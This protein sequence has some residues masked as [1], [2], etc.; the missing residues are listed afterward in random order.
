MAAAIAITAAA[1]STTAATAA[2]TY[3]VVWYDCYCYIGTIVAT[4]M[5]LAH[6]LFDSKLAPLAV[7]ELP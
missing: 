3:T 5:L 2:V 4:V 7:N 1:I 6:P